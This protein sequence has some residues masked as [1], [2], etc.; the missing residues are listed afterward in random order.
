MAY[1]NYNKLWE[2]ESDNFFFE[3]DKVQDMK[4]IQLKLEVHDTFKEMQINNKL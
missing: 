4:I 3:K 1:M 2:S